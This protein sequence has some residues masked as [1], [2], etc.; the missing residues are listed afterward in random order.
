[1]IFSLSLGIIGGLGIFIFGML[2]LNDALQ[3]MAG[4]R[5]QKIALTLTRSPL[6]GFITGIGVTLANQSSSATALMEVSMVSAGLVTF[7]QTM[8]VTMG[9]EIGSTVTTQLIAFNISSYAA[10]IAGFGFFISFFSRTK[11]MKHIGEAL[12]GFGLL[13]VGIKIMSE[14]IIPLRDR[15]VL[16]HFLAHSSNPLMGIAAG[17]A[18]T[19]LIHSSGA[20]S[21]I[22]IVLAMAGTI[23]LSQAVFINLGAQIGTCATAVLGSFNR[24]REAKRVALWHV[25]HQT[26]GVILVYPFLVLFT[27]NGEPCWLYFI[28]WVTRSMCFSED[29]SRQIAMAHTLVAVAN[30]LVFLPLLPL[31]NRVMTALFPAR[32]IEKPFGPIYI[33][34]G[35]LPTPTLA[36]E[37]ARKE[38][39][40]EGEIVLEMMTDVIKVF[41]ARDIMMSETVSLK[42]IRADVLRNAVVPYL[43]RVAQNSVLEEDQ[44]LLEIQL[45]YIAADFEEI[46]DIVDKNIMPLVRKHIEN[47]LWFSDEG[48]KDINDLHAR[49]SN[50]LKE[51][52]EALRTG[53]PEIARLILD[54]KVDINAYESELRKRHISRLHTGLQEALETSSIHLDLIDQFR[55]INS[56]VASVG[57]ALL[58]QV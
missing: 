6:R 22:V 25:V 9:A 41:T 26:L 56:H 40:R 31:M 4:N 35:L 39:V 58:G 8:A 52:I 19:L 1:M 18:I 2:Y 36:L 5:I 3:K 43:A 12:L 33:D 46:G 11:K 21:G 55:R 20:T 30:A 44:S 10:F 53:N 23:N 14:L 49:V 37:Q 47:N 54:S 45:V 28:K 32:D 57:A 15:G 38:I 24:G 42:D 50:N 48:W 34:E 16:E 13:F 27:Y 29:L 51:S 17:L 7:Y